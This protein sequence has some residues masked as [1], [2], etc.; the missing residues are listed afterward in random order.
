MKLNMKI[1]LFLFGLSLLA[2]GVI[3][4]SSFAINNSKNEVNVLI[5]KDLLF[6]SNTKEIYT[7]GLQRG[8]A[9]R[10]IILNPNDKKAKENFDAASDV[11]LK[12]ADDLTSMAGDYGLNDQINSLITLTEKDIQLQEQAIAETQNDKEIALKL[13]TEEET[14]VWRNFKEEYFSIEKEIMKTFELNQK[15]NNNMMEFFLN[16]IYILLA[17]FVIVSVLLFIFMRKIIT[18]PITTL[19][20]NVNRLAN[21]DLTIEPVDTKS[22]DEIGILITS[23]NKM[24]MDFRKMVSQVKDS[25]ENVAA[26]SEELTAS[27][28]QSAK[29]SEMISLATQQAAAGSEDQLKGVSEAASSIEQMSAGIQQASASS[30]EVSRISENA[31]KASEN[32]MIAVEA[33]VKQMGEI[34]ETVN[35]L[36]TIITG[37][38][39]RSK[40]IG[41]I[42]V[43]ITNISA[44]TNL[45]AL[46]AAIEAARAGEHGKGFAVVADEVRKLAEQSAASAQQISQL[47]GDIQNETVSAVNSMDSGTAKVNEGIE[48]TKLVS[49][50]FQEIEKAINQVTGNTQEV[51]ATMEELSAASTQIVHAI[52]IVKETAETGAEMNESNS[53]ITQEQLA[54]M[55]E[56]SAS[57]TSLSQLSEELQQSVSKFRI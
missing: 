3:S 13:I 46:N 25:A 51:S 39:E 44:Q 53:A 34:N 23:F 22:K 42:V 50:S 32:G 45:L 40:E 11:S 56:I 55:E 1:F 28:E 7:Q 30:M 14:P 31:S 52:E 15:E 6:L 33:V 47:I 26:A 29:A 10:N 57:A 27:A 4:L 43:L 36:A 9:V 41:E 8:Q 21:G 54:A 19:S 17:I 2:V 49:D 18:V 24:I 16:L 48:K 38:G 35:G 12:I 20:G 37:L 5:E